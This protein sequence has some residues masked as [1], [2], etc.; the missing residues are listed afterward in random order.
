MKRIFPITLGLA[1]AGMV[2]MG[3][4][5]PAWAGSEPSCDQIIAKYEMANPQL[6]PEELAKKMHVSEKRVRKCLE[7]KA[8]NPSDTPGAGGAQPND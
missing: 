1:L 3:G 8:A 7:T 2:F 4:A 5:L 6:S